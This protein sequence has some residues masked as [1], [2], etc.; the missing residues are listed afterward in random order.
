MNG[1][2]NDISRYFRI[3][4]SVPMETFQTT[5]TGRS[6]RQSVYSFIRMTPHCQCRINYKLVRRHEIIDVTQVVR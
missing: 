6:R 1:R 4:G 2:Q 3:R 5:T